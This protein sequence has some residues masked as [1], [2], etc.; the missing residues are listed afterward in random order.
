MS[1]IS[2]D[3]NELYSSSGGLLMASKRF[4]T[5]WR[6]TV[7]MIA[8]TLCMTGMCAA[9]EKVLYSFSTGADGNYPEAGLILGSAGN[10]YGTTFRGGANHYGTVFE[11][12]PTA[13]G[14]WTETVLYSFNAGQDGKYPQA[15]LIFDSASN[16]YGTTN[17]GGTYGYGTVFELARHPGGVWTETVLYSFKGG[18]DGHNPQAGLIFGAAGNLFGT[19]NGGGTYGFGTVF[20]LA[21]T[22]GGWTETVLHSFDHNN[23]KDGIYPSAG[24][25]L[26]AFGNLYGT[27]NQGGTYGYG[28]VFE[29]KRNG[30][31]VWT[32]KLLYS[33]NNNISDGE[34]P[35][36]S[37]IFDASGNLY[38]TTTKGGATGNGTVFELTP[39]GTGGWT[40]TVLYSFGSVPDGNGPQGSLIFD[41][42]GNLYGTTYLGGVNGGG[43]VFELT[44][45]GG[46]AWTETVLHSFNVTLDGRKPW[47]G[48]IFGAAGNLYGTTYG[49]GTNRNG[50]VFQIEP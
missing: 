24:L 49:G 42:L 50:T 40:E 37:L 20:E 44:P 1:A 39:T 10:L 38:G 41:A 17:Q 25:I 32:E 33:F 6:S 12:T 31:G 14:G 2:V 48:V 16:L 30:G 19:T 26:D 45:A 8:L 15:G 28:T 11:L 5:G 36:A 9:L 27:T 18:T 4:S 35:N 21:H 22:A 23:G 47:A 34:N 13:G 3:K 7:A 29:V 46:G 43:T